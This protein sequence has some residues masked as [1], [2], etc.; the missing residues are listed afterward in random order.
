M[1]DESDHLYLNEK[2]FNRH[3]DF[4]TYPFTIT[5]PYLETKKETEAAAA[6]DELP[7]AGF[8]PR[9][10][11]DEDS[12]GMNA[13]AKKGTFALNYGNDEEAEEE[14]KVEYNNN[15]FL[16]SLNLISFNSYKY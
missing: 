13:N 2:F 7:D 9:V 8:D 14:D 4:I 1:L 12:L 3:F 11:D 6:L 10:D 16:H 15:I 5:E